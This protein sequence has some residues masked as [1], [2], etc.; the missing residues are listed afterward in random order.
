ML[1]SSNYDVLISLKLNGEVPDKMPRFGA[2]RL[3]LHGLPNDS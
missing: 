1:E 2:Y 3:G